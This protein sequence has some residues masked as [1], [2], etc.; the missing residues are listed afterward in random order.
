MCLCFLNSGPES[1]TG[2]TSPA[3]G[4]CPPAGEVAPLQGR[5]PSHL[6]TALP[7]ALGESLCSS[8]L[9]C[10]FKTNILTNH[11]LKENLFML[12]TK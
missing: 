7:M 2:A 10:A 4:R 11:P 9:A 6:L 1:F 5:W 3:G 12:N 8:P